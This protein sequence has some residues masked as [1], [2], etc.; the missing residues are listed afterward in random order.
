MD[1]A[2][3]KRNR[4]RRARAKLAALPGR[5]A[6]GSTSLNEKAAK[7]VRRLSGMVHSAGGT[8]PV[9]HYL[10]A[11]IA[12]A[13]HR[14]RGRLLGRCERLTNGIPDEQLIAELVS[15]AQQAEVAARRRAVA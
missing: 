2:K 3:T 9:R 7:I 1:T 13:S 5:P 4:R 14:Q 10:R 8:G 12:A 6:I 11:Q 15:V